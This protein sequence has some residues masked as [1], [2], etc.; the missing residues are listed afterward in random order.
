MVYKDRELKIKVAFCYVCLLM[1]G[2]GGSSFE[3][4]NFATFF[5]M[6]M[7]IFATLFFLKGG[8][9]L[10]E[11]EGISAIVSMQGLFCDVCLFMGG[12]G[13]FSPINNSLP[14]TFFLYGGLFATF[15]YLRRGA[16]FFPSFEG[17]CATFFKGLFATFNCLL[18]GGGGRRRYFF[19]R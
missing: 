5:S 2:G 4:L 16:G 13:L 11:L 12:G 3:S 18:M 15:F 10:L 19:H 1:R 8:G 17:F 6:C 14:A 7:C 9:G